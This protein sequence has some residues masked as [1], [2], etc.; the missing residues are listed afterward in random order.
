MTRIYTHAALIVA[1]NKAKSAPANE[2][3]VRKSLSYSD[4][5]M[6]MHFCHQKSK[7]Q[8]VKTRLYH[9]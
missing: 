4:S 2:S 9:F 8:F 1:G 5:D 7:N 3:C 6:S